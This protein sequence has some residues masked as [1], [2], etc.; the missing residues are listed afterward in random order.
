MTEENDTSHGP[1]RY[2][3][4]T[5]SYHLSYEWTGQEP[6]STAVTHAIATIEGVDPERIE[7]LSETINPDALDALFQPKLDGT[8]RSDGHISFT[9]H[10]YDVTVH[11]HGKIVIS[12]R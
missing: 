12:S 7:S 5:D 10:G 3:S 9:L 11:S 2:D 8:S 6:I 4:T 1:I